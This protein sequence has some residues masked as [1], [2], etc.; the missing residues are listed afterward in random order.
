MSKRYVTYS[1]EQRRLA[2]ER[3]HALFTVECCGH[4]CKKCS[5]TY[6]GPID[7]E[8]ASKLT[9]FGILVAEGSMPKVAFTKA[10]AKKT[11]SAKK[12]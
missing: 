9:L 6:Q 2:E 3:E 8:T 11:A 10:F 1:A 12:P 5:L 7:F 4:P